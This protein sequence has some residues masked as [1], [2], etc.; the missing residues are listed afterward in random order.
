MTIGVDFYS[1]DMI[2]DRTLY[3]LVIWDMAGQ[4]RFGFMRPAFYKGSSGGFIAFSLVDDQSLQDV[5]GWVKEAEDNIGKVP[6]ILVGTKRD[7]G[8]N[9]KRDPR[10]LVKELGFEG[11]IETSALSGE[12]IEEA[13]KL[14]VTRITRESTK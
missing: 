14:L 9:I 3:K 5:P 7:L 10:K 4:E 11:Y 8:A 13:V 2:I 12:N 6:L 1:N